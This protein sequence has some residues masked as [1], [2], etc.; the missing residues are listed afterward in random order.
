MTDFSGCR[1]FVLDDFGGLVTRVA[2][3]DVRPP[4]SPDNQNIEFAPGRVFS[5]AGFTSAIAPANTAKWN[6]LGTYIDR[7]TTRRLVG[8]QSNGELR[9]ATSTLDTQIGADLYLQVC[10]LYGRAYISIS[11]G[12]QGISPPRVWDG[13]NLDPYTYGPPGFKPAGTDNAAA[14]VVAAGTRICAYCFRLRDGTIS[15]PV[16]SAPFN[17]A[18]AKKLDIIQVGTGPAQTVARMV[19]I[20]RVGTANTIWSSADL[21][22]VPDLFTLNDNLQNQILAANFTE[23]QLLSGAPLADYMA[24]G[25]LPPTLGTT[26]YHNR[27]VAW[28]CPPQVGYRDNALYYLQNVVPEGPTALNLTFEGG[29]TLGIPHGWVLVGAG[30]AL[31][32]EAGSPRRVWKITGDGATAVRGRL[33]QGIPVA[34]SGSV[35]EAMLKL[36]TSYGARLRLKK[37][38]GATTGRFRVELAA[39]GGFTTLSATVD[40]SAVSS[41]GW[42]TVSQPAFGTLGANYG[43]GL[44]LDIMSDQVIPTGEWVKCQ[45]IEFY[46]TDVVAGTADPTL[47][48]SRAFDPGRYSA[49][50]GF[51]VVNKDDGQRI[52]SCFVLR[53][54]LYIAKERSLWLTTDTGTAEPSGWP[55]SQ[56][57][58][59]VGTP[60]VMGVGVG[61]GWAVIA[62]RDGLYYFDGG[63][64]QKMSQEI[65]PSWEDI[66]WTYGHR[67][68]V[69]VNTETKGVYVGVPTGTATEPNRIYHLDYE[70]GWAQRGWTIWT[71]G[72]NSGAMIELSTGERAFYLGTN[73][74]SGKVLQYDPT[75]HSDDG[76]PFE[77]YY[78]TATI[79]RD[80][81]LALIQG[82]VFQMGGQGRATIS[83]R[84]ADNVLRVIRQVGLA[85]PW[86]TEIEFPV[87]IAAERAGIRVAMNSA[88]DHFI[89]ER[90]AVM[91]K[92][93]PLNARGRT[94]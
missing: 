39:S 53:G 11:D 77:S 70:E 76:E 93:H 58:E 86:R 61:D 31:D 48:V 33:Q 56:V 38:A 7:A 30:G 36:N 69:V 52:T 82:L 49:V 45:G 35:L 5:R 17:T 75:E 50:D 4:K 6:G 94:P 72:A 51:V 25:L 23:A 46:P 92:A 91:L 87:H 83:H 44:Q 26:P 73:G 85:D 59:T 43:T 89:L 21:F 18:G 2:R 3:M 64:P 9:D 12:K 60:S 62:A 22:W 28:G 16:F 19:F 66:N 8:L 1:A 27:M 47:R 71:I 68:W 80:E 13:T 79:G 55:V 90:L 88:T 34:T 32:T 54:N 67:I 74:G 15:A 29:E 10:Q 41:T 42:T 84:L 14:G 37:S 40:L 65:Q 63:A 81:G 78:E 20:S 57:S 24:A